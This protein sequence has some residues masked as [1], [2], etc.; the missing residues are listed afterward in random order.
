MLADNLA[1]LLNDADEV[2]AELLSAAIELARERGMEVE[3][4]DREPRPQPPSPGSQIDLESEGVTSIIWCTGYRPAFDWI[5]IP[6]FDEQGAP[7]QKRGQT[8]CPGLYFLGLHW[9]HT[10]KSGALFGGRR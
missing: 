5:E 6:V 7:V 3:E 1:Q 8:S 9:M 4:P 10:L 2:C